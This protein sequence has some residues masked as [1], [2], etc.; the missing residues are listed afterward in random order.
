EADLKN[1][2]RII[3]GE[4]IAYQM[5]KRYVHARGHF[6]TVLLNVSL[7]R[8]RQGEPRYFISHLQD[9]SERK[10]TENALRESH[11]QFH[12]LA[13]NITDAFWIRSPDMSQVHYVSQAF[14]RIW[15]RTADSL[16]A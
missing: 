11:E 5:E 1:L 9:I 13:D 14:E 4:I 12:Q 3:A 6:V 8:D 10:Q 2:R 16:S 7:V 15:G